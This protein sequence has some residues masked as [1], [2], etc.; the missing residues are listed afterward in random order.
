MILREH[1]RYT[2]SLAHASLP[3]VPPSGSSSAKY[4]SR[5]HPPAE[6][7]CGKYETIPFRPKQEVSNPPSFSV[8]CVWLGTTSPTCLLAATGS[9]VASLGLLGTICS[10]SPY[11]VSSNSVGCHLPGILHDLLKMSEKNL[12]N[13]LLL[14]IRPRSIQSPCLRVLKTFYTGCLK[15]NMDSVSL[16]FCSKSSSPFYSIYPVFSALWFNVHSG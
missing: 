5:D 3:M 15:L 12:E 6:G 9:A 14:Q 11:W 10:F 2:L 13:P 1:L 7:I 8:G 4:Q 16:H